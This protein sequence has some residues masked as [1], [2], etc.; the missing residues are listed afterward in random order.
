MAATSHTFRSNVNVRFDRRRTWKHGA[1]NVFC[2]SYLSAFPQTAPPQTR[3]TCHL[4]STM[5][6]AVTIVVLLLTLCHS[7]L[8]A[9]FRGDGSKRE[10]TVH[11]IEPF[12]FNHLSFANPNELFRFKLDKNFT[13][14]KLMLWMENRHTK[15]QWEAA[16]DDDVSTYGPVG[17]PR[18]A[19]FHFLEK[20]LG[21]HEIGRVAPVDDTPMTVVA[22]ACTVMNNGYLTLALTL[23]MSAMWTNDYKF[24]LGPRKVE[25]V[26]V[27]K[28]KLV[29]A[30]EA[31]AA[32]QRKIVVLKGTSLSPT[33]DYLVS[34]NSVEYPGTTSTTVVEKLVELKEYGAAKKL[35]TIKILHSGVY[36]YIARSTNTA[37]YRLYILSAGTMDV[38]AMSFSPAPTNSVGFVTLVKDIEYV[39]Y[40]GSGATWDVTLHLE[41]KMPLD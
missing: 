40:C 17:V 21:E 5:K 25:I 34:W 41:L 33:T 30:E 10:L 36:S 7:A 11:P 18:H 3:T 15:D 35:A 2:H 29:D 38:E 9:L 22:V 26:D 19:L 27:L 39:M 20:A 8:A 13:S 6:L 31:I 24:L 4:C 37:V 16:V 28:S 14:G 32:L 12:E 1:R 23:T